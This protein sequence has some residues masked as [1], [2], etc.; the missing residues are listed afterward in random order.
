MCVLAW[1]DG[2]RDA[3]RVREL[4]GWCV[5]THRATSIVAASAGLSKGLQSYLQ[6]YYE[7]ADQLTKHISYGS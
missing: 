7:P 5:A 1:G 6:F 4:R 2:Q 3:S